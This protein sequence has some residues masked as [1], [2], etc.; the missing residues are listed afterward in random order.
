MKLRYS[1]ICFLNNIIFA[2]YPLGIIF[3][4]CFV[5]FISLSACNKLVDIDPPSATI[6]NENVYSDNKIAISVLTGIYADLVSSFTG[7]TLYGISFRTGLSSD[8]LT[9]FGDVT[10]ATNL[11]YYK[12]KLASNIN[13]NAAFGGDIWTKFY[14]VI[15]TCN[16]AI[17]GI[18]K[19][20]TLTASVKQQLLGEALFIRAFSYFYLVN[21]YGDAPLI[22]STD[23]KIAT[24]LPRTNIDNVYK[25]IVKDLKESQGLLSVKYLNKDLLPYPEA[26]SER[27]RPTKWAATALLARV[28]LYT[29]DYVNS[30]IEASKVISETSLYDTLPLNK[31]FLKNNKE[32]IWQLQ[33]VENGRNN[34]DAYVFVL[35]ESGPN[36]TV[37]PVYLSNSLIAAFESGDKRAIAGN[38]VNFRAVPQTGQTYYY[39]FKYK[40]T[41][42]SLTEYPVV[43]RLAEQYLIRAEARAQLN[44]LSASN[45]AVVDLNVIRSRAGLM[46]IAVSTKEKMLE[47]IFRERRV[48]FFLEWGHRWLDLKRGENINLIMKAAAIEK[49]TQ[50]EPYQQL[51][52]LPFKDI[53][54]SPVLKQNN[55]YTSDRGSMEYLEKR[56][57]LLDFGSFYA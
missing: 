57:G 51:Y 3:I 33:P 43:L 26:A 49:E 7:S 10:D 54:Y 52:P 41:V 56:R 4:I 34:E 17:E 32:A 12:N 39:A 36:A 25:Q 5:F 27:I 9:L 29:R 35:P 14:S 42:G 19:S 20:P 46:P 45:G 40:A 23:P 15:F 1:K 53:Q 6:N 31:V 38:W 55:G 2:I 30:E 44:R 13:S 21:L 37:N 48:E 28:Y 8:E 18:S 24:L 11:A 22:I 16:A 47:D 50:W